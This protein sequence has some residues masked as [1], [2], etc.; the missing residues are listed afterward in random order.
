[1]MIDCVNFKIE[2]CFGICKENV[3]NGQSRKTVDNEKVIE[4]F[5]MI[6]DKEYLARKLAKN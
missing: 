2:K 1:M 3:L 4:N 6:T 5:S